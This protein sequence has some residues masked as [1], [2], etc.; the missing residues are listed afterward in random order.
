MIWLMET[1]TLLAHP[2]K[3]FV[4]IVLIMITLVNNYYIKIVLIIV[5]II[6]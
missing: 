2:I 1:S 3:Q 4:V 6:F 5:F